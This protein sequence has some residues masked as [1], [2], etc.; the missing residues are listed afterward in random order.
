MS[1]KLKTIKNYKMADD[2]LLLDKDNREYVLRVQDM[3]LSARPRERLIQQGPEVLSLVELLAVILNSGNKNE[4]VMEMSNRIVREYGEKSI[5]AEKN[6]KKISKEFGISIIKSC[7]IIA[8]GEIGKRFYNK[9]ENGFTY[10]RNAK[11]T[12]E[13]L[14]DMRSLPK[15]HF[16]GLYLNSHNQIIHDEVISIGTINTNIVH[17]REVFRPA[18]E[19]NAVAIVLAH[20]HPSNVPTPSTQDIEITKQLVSVGKLLGINILDHVVITKNTY[21]SIVTDY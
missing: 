5:F 1:S 10:I 19:Y 9:N 20:N 8:C 2:V 14:N 18:I 12:Y 13:Y 3:P 17:P 15:E 11:D 7:Q 16:R 4:G 21:M 6:A